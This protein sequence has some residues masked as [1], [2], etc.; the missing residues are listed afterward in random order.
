M[1]KGIVVTVGGKGIGVATSRLAAERGY[2]VCVNYVGIGKA[3][4][5]VVEKCRQARVKTIEVRAVVPVEADVV[6]LFET[7]DGEPGRV[8][9][10]VNNTGILETFDIRRRVVGQVQCRD[11]RPQI[12]GR[13][14]TGSWTGL[15]FQTVPP[16]TPSLK[17]MTSA[18]RQGLAGGDEA[19]PV[20]RATHAEGGE[21]EGVDLGLGQVVATSHVTLV[22]GPGESR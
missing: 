5:Q 13:Q 21:V 18:L 22:S 12:T 7:V 14:R 6:R 9:A 11:S 4:G 15:D 2:A 10:L 16:S 8:I 19:V 17:N 1:D 20:P 3:A